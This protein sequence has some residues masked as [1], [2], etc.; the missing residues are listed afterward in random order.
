M[1]TRKLNS[2]HTNFSIPF[3]KSKM[4][5]WLVYRNELRLL[6]IVQLREVVILPLGIKISGSVCSSLIF[7]VRVSFC[8]NCVLVLWPARHQQAFRCFRI[9]RAGF[10]ARFRLSSFS[11]H[12]SINYLLFTFHSCH[13]AGQAGCVCSFDERCQKLSSDKCHEARNK[14]ICHVCAETQLRPADKAAAFWSNV[15]TNGDFLA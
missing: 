11:F 5:A 10:V 1:R 6:H 7:F 15:F 2:E 13:P 8:V 12:R 9:E 4:L 3:I 14:E